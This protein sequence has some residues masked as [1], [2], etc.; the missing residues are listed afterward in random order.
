[1]L[2]ACSPCACVPEHGRAQQGDVEEAQGSEEHSNPGATIS[3]GCQETRHRSKGND[4][5]QPEGSSP[6]RQESS[7]IRK[8]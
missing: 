5:V 1:M 4:S 6:T 8:G 7:K 3:G 2:R